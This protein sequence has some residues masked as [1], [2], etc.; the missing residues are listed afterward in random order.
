MSRPSALAVLRL[1]TRL[2]LLLCKT[3]R[4]GL[5]CACA[6]RPHGRN[7]FRRLHAY[8]YQ[9][10]RRYHPS[11]QALR[12]NGPA[13]RAGDAASSAI[14]HRR[15]PTL[16][17]TAPLE[18]TSQQLEAETTA[19]FDA[20]IPTRPNSG[21]AVTTAICKGGSRMFFSFVQALILMQASSC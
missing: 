5:D 9:E 21:P 15:D 6:H 4:N 14:L 12:G 3:G 11:P 13:H 18:L 2:N 16:A 17:R 19:F 20:L 10:P 1:I 8:F 7:R